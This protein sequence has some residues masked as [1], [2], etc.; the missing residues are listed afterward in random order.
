MRTIVMVDWEIV[1]TRRREGVCGGESSGVLCGGLNVERVLGRRF[2][3][4]Q[5]EL[6]AR[7]FPL[8]IRVCAATREGQVIRLLVVIHIHQPPL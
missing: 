6:T 5:C 3:M 4:M 1:V 8:L 2:W 7:G